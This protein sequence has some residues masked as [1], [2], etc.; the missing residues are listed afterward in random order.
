MVPLKRIIPIA[1]L[2]M[3]GFLSLYSQQGISL[4]VTPGLDIPFSG[5][6]SDTRTIT[7]WGT[8]KFYT[9]GG[10]LSLRGNWGL[11]GYP[12]YITGGLDTDMIGTINEKSMTMLGLYGGGGYSYSNY[13]FDARGD[14]GIG[15]ALGTYSN[16]S[17]LTNF[18]A[19]IGGSF[20]FNIS[21]TLSVGPS[22]EYRYF[23]NN[24]AGLTIGVTAKFAPV[25]PISED[26]A[27]F[28]G[29][30]LAPVYP[31]LYRN[32]QTYP[33]GLLSFIN[34]EKETIEELEIYFYQK[35]YMEKSALCGRYARVEP[36]KTVSVPIA[37]PLKA[38]TLANQGEVS[39][40]GEI[41]IRYKLKGRNR[42]LKTEKTFYLED[43]HR[44][45]DDNP[46]KSA[47]F[48][49]P[50]EESLKEYA[51]SV[52]DQLAGVTMS[53]VDRNFRTA[54]GLYASLSGLQIGLKTT[55]EEQT[56]V[57]KNFQYPVETLA[58]RSGEEKDLV[59]AYAA[60]LDAAGIESA[61]I[62]LPRKTMAALALILPREEA[63]SILDKNDY[64]E[65]LNKIWIPL[66]LSATDLAGFIDAWMSGAAAWNSTPPEDRS[67][68]SVRDAWTRYKPVESYPY[69]ERDG[70]T[71]VTEAPPVADI[72]EEE[73]IAFVE[74]SIAKEEKILLDKINRTGDVR[75]KNRLG[76][77][78]ARYGLLDKA[79][80]QFEPLSYD[81]P[82]AAVNMG[83]IFYL[84]EDYVKA[85]INY[86]AA[87]EMDKND[88]YALLG[89]A[90][91]ARMLGEQDTAESVYRTLSALDINLA[92]PFSYIV[93]K[94]I[95][96]SES[97][98]RKIVYWVEE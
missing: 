71:A 79:K 19:K 84:Q 92:I 51:R 93:N 86:I 60:L 6:D 33:S 13:L 24:F 96:P 49:T 18:Y 32:Y 27:R 3:G 7:P 38:E 40:T 52:T 42:S 90:R 31:A 17:P 45:I 76:V 56:S 62:Q 39:L 55:A 63:V 88:K 34:G 11:A 25:P 10:S 50:G 43:A 21:S 91:T 28:I 75:T 77:L 65:D 2:F 54:M 74:K 72:Y 82:A 14:L 20:L 66:D 37:L 35:D 78:Y 73:L 4:S 87:S 85:Y 81:Y 68:T 15:G 46:D 9:M 26:Q 57:E 98:T 48:V 47:L 70:L 53:P 30:Q 95:E 22:A 58:L 12:L 64:I 67:I 1:L 61:I 97:E 69:L 94:D 5:G 80:A 29:I 36:G 41:T 44:I 8:E 16:A 89:K 59:T 23:H 83:N